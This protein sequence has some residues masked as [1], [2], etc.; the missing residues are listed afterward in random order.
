MGGGAEGCPRLVCG[1]IGA[2]GT[3]RKGEEVCETMQATISAL[4]VLVSGVYRKRPGERTNSGGRRCVDARVCERGSLL[5][6]CRCA[7]LRRRSGGPSPA[8]ALRIN[9]LAIFNSCRTSSC[10]GHAYRCSLLVQAGEALERRHGSPKNRPRWLQL[11]AGLW[12][13]GGGRCRAHISLQLLKVVAQGHPV[14]HHPGHKLRAGAGGGR[15][16]SATCR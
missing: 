15:G 10:V 16:D 13:R 9:I 2:F 5:H 12:P 11:G 4:E 7:A 8:R 1:S 14:D 6:A 3:P